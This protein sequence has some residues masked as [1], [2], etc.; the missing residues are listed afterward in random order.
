[1]SSNKQKIAKIVI[2][3]SQ[4]GYFACN[5]TNSETPVQGF[6]RS[7][8][9]PK[10]IAPVPPLAAGISDSSFSLAEGE[11]NP[12]PNNASPPSGN[13]PSSSNPATNSSPSTTNS[14]ETPVS[15]RP[16]DAI[17]AGEGQGYWS[18]PL[19]G[20][21]TSENAGLYQYYNEKGEAQ[22]WYGNYGK[23]ASGGGVDRDSSEKTFTMMQAN[24]KGVLDKSMVLETQKNTTGW[25]GQ[26]LAEKDKP[27]SYGAGGT[28]TIQNKSAVL[29]GGKW[30]YAWEATNST[31]ATKNFETSQFD[32]KGAPPKGGMDYKQKGSNIIQKFLPMPAGRGVIRIAC[33]QVSRQ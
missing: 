6:Q 30:V 19:N 24:D 7:N 26:I 20:K 27:Y 15:S 5:S 13:S 2:A 31:G 22:P 4:L 16:E 18:E 25:S 10:Q 23:L 14:T 21:V 29:Q 9:A 3:I 33:H 28:N 17:S 8:S 32:L 1:M 11:P 12:L